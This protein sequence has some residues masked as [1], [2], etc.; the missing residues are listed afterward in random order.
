M[1]ACHPERREGSAVVW[2]AALLLIAATS[3]EAQGTLS[4]QG[5][6]FPPG[7]LGTA[8]RT[9]GGAIGEADPFSPLNPAAIGLLGGAI[10]AMQAEPE[11]RTVV[12]GSITQRTAVARF[13]LFQGAMQLG[14]RWGVG[15]ATST[16]LDRTWETSTRDTQVIAGQP[17]PATVSEHSDGSIADTRIAL[18]YAITPWFRVGLSGH[19]I[20]GRDQLHT[21]RAFDDT[22]RFATDTQATNL[23]F[24]GNAVSVGAVASLGRKAI[25]GASYRAGGGVS[26]ETATETVGTGSVPDRMGVSLVYTGING[27]ALALRVAKDEW[28]S[29]RGMAKNLNIHEG[30]DIGAGAEVNGPSVGSNQMAFRFGGRWRTLPFSPNATPV[31]EQTYSTGF[32]LPMARGRIELNVGGL[33]ANRTNGAISGAKEKAWTISTGFSVRP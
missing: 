17:I 2:A 25:I 31:K 21:I 9:M 20:S 19:A 22:D 33:Y 8:A 18:S 16:L 30:L 15:V 7:Q 29:L 5:L 27:A 13:P 3:L 23:S 4:T 28:S 6:G 14:S 24:G 26:S 32:S 1:R 11:Y 12:V 10:I